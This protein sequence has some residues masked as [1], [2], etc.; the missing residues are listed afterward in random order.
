LSEAA[1]MMPKRN[2]VIIDTN[3]WI[4]FLLTGDFVKL[5]NLLINGSIVLLFSQELLNEFIE[6]A[7]RPKFKGYFSTQTLSGLLRQ[8]EKHAE[9]IEVNSNVDFCRDSK[10]NFLLSLA[11]DGQATHIITGD[12]DLLVIEKFGSI[13][14]LTMTDFLLRH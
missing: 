3:L 9:F 14:I 1:D 2:R 11:K 4:S 5:D 12:K 10:D 7:G 8:I 13:E 6:V